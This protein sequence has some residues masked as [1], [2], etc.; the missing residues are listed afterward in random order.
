MPSVGGLLVAGGRGERARSDGLQIPKQ[1]APL[2]GRPMISWSFDALHAGG[3]ESI[4]VAVPPTYRDAARDL[5]G[6]EA[7][8][9]VGGDTRQ[10]SVRRGLAAVESEIVIVHDAV[11]PF[12]GAR[13]VAAVAAAAAESGG[14]LAAVPVDETLKSVWKGNVVETVDRSRLWS[15]QT[16]QGFRTEVLRAA[17][18]KAVN[19]GF[20]ATDDAQLVE[21]YEGRVVVVPGSRTNLKITYPEDLVLAQTFVEG[22]T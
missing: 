1:F 10:E 5:F 13:L 7:V 15:A 22:T 21:R 18:V 6:G 20:E 16:P 11:R 4:V 14:A 8:I 3:C 12:A 2:G 9:V 17:H 19:E